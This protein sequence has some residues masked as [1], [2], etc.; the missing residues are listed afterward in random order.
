MTEG[1]HARIL[2]LCRLL[3]LSILF[4]LSAFELT[5]AQ[6]IDGKRPGV[7]LTFKEFVKKTAGEAYPS[8]GA[9]LVLHNNTRWPIYY[10]RWYETTLPGD[11]A[12]IYN[13]EQRDGCPELRRHVEQ[14][15]DVKLLPG[16]AVSFTVPREDFPEGSSLYVIYN[17]SW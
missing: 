16:R 17:F 1:T 2:V 5:Q 8:Q 15:A 12:M 6:K 9:R 3:S 4:C 13:I 7:Y 14:V 11:A 10:G